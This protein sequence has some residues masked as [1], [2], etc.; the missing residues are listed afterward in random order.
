M[1][2]SF[3]A[4][5]ALCVLV[6]VTQ[7]PATI[8]V[9][10]G[11]AF[12]TIGAAVAAARPGDTLRIRPAIYRER[13]V[14]ETPLVLWGEPG[15]VIDGGGS[16]TV[17]TLRAPA[18]V[19]GLTIRG[20]GSDLQREHAGILAERAGGVVIEDNNIED[21]LFGIYV[22]QSPAAV[23]LGNRIEGKELPL[24]MRGD[25]I[26]LW[27]SPRGVIAGNGVRR[28]RD[29]VIWFSDH[30]YVHDNVVRDGRYGLHYMYSHHSRFEDNEFRGNHVGGFLMYSQ[31]IAFRRNLFADSRG[32]T[33]MGL[34][35]KDADRIR[36]EENWILKNAVGIYID[37]SPSRVD[38]TNEFRDNV[39]AFND[40]GVVPL[41]SVRANFFAGNAFLN[42]VHPVTVSGGG[43]ALANRWWGNAW[44][45]YAGFDDDGDGRGDHPFVYERWSDDLLAKHPALRW[46][47][48]SPAIATLDMLGRFFPLLQ[49]QP[50]VVDSA[51]RLD[52][53][54]RE[55]AAAARRE[56]ARASA[57][58]FLAVSALAGAA[59]VRL[60][61][62]FRKAA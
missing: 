59:A 27:Y 50:I 42:N 20:S 55:P 61:R 12:P 31:D 35:L 3:V 29:V 37:N 15:A 44:S 33:G 53:G 41:P 39:I 36:A 19:F 34:G 43:H 24:A 2:A 4:I 18:V 1:T 23:V 48:W 58:A 16:G 11:T 46:Y 28:T 6:P 54:L 5:G 21:V 51:P 40:V 52:L 45:E 22:K 57:A 9:G 26:R 62:P 60:R 17:L 38:A 30:L 32:A 7:T 49:P 47:E 13:P 8:E 10:P 25:G 56:P 14:V